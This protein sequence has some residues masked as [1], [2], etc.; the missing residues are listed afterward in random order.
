MKYIRRDKF[1][2]PHTP[3]DV[4]KLALEKEKSSY[5][6]YNKLL[7]EAK[8]PALKTLLEELKNAEWGHIQRIER[9]LEL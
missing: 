9:K 8:F 7:E 4:L 2:M 5:G 1:T 6:F 3:A